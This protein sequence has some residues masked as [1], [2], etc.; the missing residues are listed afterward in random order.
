MVTCKRMN[1]QHYFRPYAKMS[2]KWIKGLNVRPEIIK[3]PGKNI[4]GKPLDIDLNNGF[5]KF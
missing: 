3:H 2:L 5:L 4:V 1:L